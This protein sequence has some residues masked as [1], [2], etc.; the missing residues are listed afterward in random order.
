MQPGFH[1]RKSADTRRYRYDIGLDDA[2]ASPFR[3][4]FEWA[5][6]RPLDTGA[7]RS[8][9]RLLLGEHD[10]RAFAAKGAPKPHYRCRLVRS[11][12]E[13]RPEGRGVSFHVEADRF[14][15]HMVRML[16]GTMVDI[17]LDRR[18]LADVEAL[19][20]RARQLGDQPAG[21]APG[22]LLRRGHLPRDALRGRDRGGRCA[23]GSGVAP[24]WCSASGLLACQDR[25]PAVR[26]SSSGAQA[27][28]A[29][30]PARQASVDAVAA[31]RAGD[32]GRARLAGGGLDQR[33]RAPRGAGALARGT[34]SSCPSGSRVV[35]GYGTGFVIRRRRHHRHQSAR[36][37]QRRA[38][39]GD[40]AR[41]HRPPRHR[42]GRGSADR[43]RRA[44][45]EA[46]GAAHGERRAE[47]RSHDRRVGRGPGQSLRLPARQRRSPPSRS[48]W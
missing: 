21:A 16:V 11:Q 42:A 5:L 12:W 8:A 3:R 47:H 41:R 20:E 26:T 35:E 15:H 32:G 6:G 46:A 18:P 1:A 40:P 34:S 45:G 9:A 33:H 2:A 22:A 13:A 25:A 23:R 30:R 14:L 10:F 27:A 48:A 4:R 36:G 7:L 37:R 39:G 28:V 31:H 19:L 44:P 17:G 38:R 24:R 43:H 29:T